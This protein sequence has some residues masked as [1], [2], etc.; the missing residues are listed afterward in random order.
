MVDETA[1]VDPET[2]R[3]ADGDAWQTHGLIRA[4][5]GGAVAEHPGVRTMTS[6]L[7][8]PQWN[9]ADV[10]DPARVDVAG[11]A[12]WYARRGVP[13]GFRVPAGAEWVHG[14]RLFRCRLMA[15]DASMLRP[16]TGDGVTVRAAAERDIREVVAV[17]AQ[18]FGGDPAAAWM[19]PLLRSSRAT[20]ALASIRGRAVGTGYVLR[21]DGWAGPSA[22]LAGIGVLPA[23]RR[24]G[25]GA[26]LSSWL[27]Q[28]AFEDGA[29]I[30]VLNPDND[31]AARV[32]SR[33][34]F[35]EVEGFDIYA[36]EQAPPA[37]G[38]IARK[39]SRRRAP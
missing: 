30:S 34:G 3:A 18:A 11:V 29:R 22:L 27:L 23:A 1:A 24:R 6:G 14:R 13:W 35:S 2:A 20:V 28:R 32:Y 25:V 31:D 36:G 4:A 33:L 8:H 37:R 17:D 26:A 39:G 15:L 12:R 16:T 10:H 38:I 21:S 5:S 19:L 7:P 9:N